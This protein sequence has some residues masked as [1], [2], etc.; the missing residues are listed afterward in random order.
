[1]YPLKRLRQDIKLAMLPPQIPLFKRIVGIAVTSNSYEVDVELRVLLY[2]KLDRFDLLFVWADALSQTV[3]E[4]ADLHYRMHQLSA[5]I[6]KYPLADSLTGLNPEKAARESFARAERR[7]ERYNQVFRARNLGRG[8]TMN[9]ELNTARNW[10]K[11]VLGETPNLTSILDKMD[12]TEGASLGVHGNATNLARKL[13]ATSWSVNPLS[14]PYFLS[15]V[16][17]NYH[18]TELLLDDS[19]GSSIFCL[20]LDELHKRFTNRLEAVRYNKISFVPKTAKTHRAIAVEPLGN[21]FVQH[22]IDSE[23]RALLKRVNLDLRNQKINQELAYLGSIEQEDPYC[24]IDLSSASDTLATEVVRNLLPPDWFN[25][26]NCTRSPNYQIDGVVKPYHK[27][28]SMGN[29][30]CFPLQTLIFASVCHAAAVT[31]HHKPDFRVY[32][33]DIIVRRSIFP[34][35]LQ[36]L[37]RLGFTPNPRKTFSLGDRKSVV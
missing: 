33:D 17:R 23:L 3:Y 31:S 14:A 18:L 27:F 35:V 21:T 22:G 6:R 28:V 19:R 34:T 12:F 11:Y 7:C 30:F 8:K 16:L 25:L 32:G 15:G 20:D 26:L 10:I 4:N 1:M 37:K 36:F 2:L 5:L 13:R 9:Y 29:G 24:T